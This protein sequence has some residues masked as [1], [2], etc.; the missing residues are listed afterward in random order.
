MEKSFK[1]SKRTGTDNGARILI[2][3]DEILIAS[4]LRNTL[5]SYGYSVI[6]E[7][8]SGEDAVLLA[9]RESP[10]LIVMDIKLSGPLDGIETA[11]SIQASQK[12][13]I[14]FLTSYADEKYLERAK[15]IFPYCFLIKPFTATQ[16]QT[17]I[18]LALNVSNIE[19]ERRRIDAA[20]A[21]KTRQFEQFF[22][23]GVDLFCI[24]DKLG[25]FR[26][27]N[28]EWE[29]C[30]GYS[31]DQLEGQNALDFLHPDDIDIT[32]EAA[33]YVMN[34]DELS[35]FSNRYRARD[36]SYRWLE[37]T[38]Q[39]AEKDLIYAVARDITIRKTMENEKELLIRQLQQALE[40]IKTLQGFI[41]ICSSCKKIR[42]DEGYWQRIEKYIQDRSDAKFTHSICP[43]CLK[44]LYPDLYLSLDET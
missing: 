14:V 12:I 30:L 35:N 21:A 39:L 38:A 22:N 6:S 20:L 3:E 28:K 33:N 25:V 42:D 5:N 10:D 17:T 2:V 26:K 13:P 8:A 37:W 18:K 43:D 4:D 34:H 40:E 19:K 9:R 24:M 1:G 7:V 23:I 44:N 29:R 41:P 36:G 16:L 11:E 31:L 32:R 27:L 15:F